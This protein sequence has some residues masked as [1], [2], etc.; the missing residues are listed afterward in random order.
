M[1]LS[2]IEVS[3]NVLLSPSITVTG[4]VLLGRNLTIGGNI[5]IAMG[6]RFYPKYEGDYIVIPK[7]YDQILDT[8]NRILLD[9]VT[10]KEITFSKTT[11]E[12]GGYTVQIGDI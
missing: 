9:D 6:A 3:G 2:T 11:N 12:K 4:D 5:H 10:V 8:D 1:R 7:V